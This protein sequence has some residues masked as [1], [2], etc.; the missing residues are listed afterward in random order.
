MEQV[1]ATTI[2][3]NGDGVMLRGPSAS[4][5][6]D[7]GLRLIDAGGRL[8][9]DDRTELTLFGGAVRASAPKEIAGRME[10]RGIGIMEVPTVP[11]TR[12]ALVVE[13][14]GAEDVERLPEPETADVL[15][16]ALPLV[17]LAPFEAS[18][19]AKVRTALKNLSQTKDQL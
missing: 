2:D 9:A 5:K 8:V 3:L 7:L 19:P 13:L 12:L 6:S 11:E 15:G 16:V 10:V 18:A 14:V 1:H 4:G 17:R